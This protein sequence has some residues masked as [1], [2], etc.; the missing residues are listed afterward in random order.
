Y[1]SKYKE[2]PKHQHKRALVLTARKFTRLVDTLLRK[3]QLYT[4]P[5]N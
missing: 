5:R 3:H 4:P 2:V 1:Q